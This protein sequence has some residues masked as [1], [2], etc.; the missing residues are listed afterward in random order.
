MLVEP[1][2]ETRCRVM[3]PVRALMDWDW[4]LLRRRSPVCRLVEAASRPLACWP[5][6]RDEDRSRRAFPAP[7]APAEQPCPATKS[8]NMLGKLHGTE[9]GEMGTT[10]RAPVW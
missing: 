10:E 4:D 8:L 7:P 1:T 9:L 5:W 6:S 2:S 3:T